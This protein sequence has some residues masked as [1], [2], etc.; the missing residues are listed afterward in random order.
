MAFSVGVGLT[1]ECN[2]R[3]AHCYR[4]D[5]V[6]DRLSL[7]DVQA[8]CASIPIKS[9]NLG[10]GRT[11]FIRSMRPSS[12]ISGSSPSRRRAASATRH[13]RGRDL[14]IVGVP[15]EP[16]N[17]LERAI[18]RGLHPVPARRAPE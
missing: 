18:H 4:P 1:N 10:V 14:V 13:A 7:S 5:M 15:T 2:L 8:V 17:S 16:V 12:I 6:V 3:C 11:G 9:V